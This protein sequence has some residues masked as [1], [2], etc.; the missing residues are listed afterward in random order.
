MPTERLSMRRIRDLLRLTYENGLSNRQIAASLGLSKGAVSVY[1]RRARVAGVT[2]PVPEEVTDTALERLLFPGQLP[3][4][5]VQ[6]PLP[7]WAYVDAELRRP[8]VTRALLWEEYRTGQPTAYGYTWFCV[9]FDAWKGKVS[10]SMR[11]HHAAGDKV[12]VDYAGSTIDVIDPRTGEARPMKLFVAAMGASSYIFA[13]ARPSEGLTDWISCHVEMLEFLG[14][15]PAIFVCD[16]LK[17]GVTKPNR[18]EPT[19]NRTYQDLA[20]HYGVAVV[21]ARPY[22][23]KDKSKVEQSVLLA[24]RWVLARLRN[25]RFF[26]QADLNIA[27]ATHV[28]DLN[29]RVMRAYGASRAELF[30]KIDAPALKG[31]PCEPFVFATWLRCRLGP[32][33]HVEVDECLYS[34]P[35]QLIKELLDV[36]VTDRTVEVFLKGVR[37]ASH[38]KAFGKRVFTSLPEHMPS[39]HRRHAAWT[40]ARIIAFGD[41]IGPAAAALFAAIMADRPHPEQGFRTCLGIIALEK[42]YGQ[43]RLAAACQRA[44]LI[45]ARSVGSVRSILQN[46]LDRA[47]LDEDVQPEPL[48]H[49]NIRGRQFF[50]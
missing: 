26:S 10:P 34:A 35:F 45:K 31:L 1:L 43:A 9:A 5:E 33:Y 7:N 30:A 11:Q 13:T 32:D 29:R 21:P 16:N 47:F 49:A 4:A 12:F 42:S 20:R 39:S 17:A 36:R 41:K 48:R 3:A 37:V 50:R 22:K 6:R 40:P 8:N 25:Q 14:G 2:W 46:G 38:A 27:I 15:A 18:Y 24:Q 19:I 44:G 28:A 23:P